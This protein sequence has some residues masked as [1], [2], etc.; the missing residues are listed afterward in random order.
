MLVQRNINVK[1][2]IIAILF[3]LILIFASFSSFFVF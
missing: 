2:W 1:M 3:F